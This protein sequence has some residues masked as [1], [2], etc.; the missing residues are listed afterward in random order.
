[1][2]SILGVGRYR[3]LERAV[4]RQRAPGNGLE[5]LGYLGLEVLPIEER[6]HEKD[7]GDGEGQ[8]DENAVN[9]FQSWPCLGA[10]GRAHCPSGAGPVD[11]G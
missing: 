3:D 1:M 6:R 5:A 9:E 8:K 2:A 7:G 11:S 4:D 10:G